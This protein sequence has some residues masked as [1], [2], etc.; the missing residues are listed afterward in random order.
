[1]KAEETWTARLASRAFT[2]SGKKTG[3]VTNRDVWWAKRAIVKVGVRKI[4]LV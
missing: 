2:V 4:S 3:R 1:M